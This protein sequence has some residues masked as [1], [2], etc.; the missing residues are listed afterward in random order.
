MVAEKNRAMN[1]KSYINAFYGIK[2]NSNISYGSKSN[3]DTIF[4]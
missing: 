1:E 2:S 4:S 3:S